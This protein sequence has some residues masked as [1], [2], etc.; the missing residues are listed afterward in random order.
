MYE[1]ERR[2]FEEKNEEM[3]WF[4]QD[5]FSAKTK[6][7]IATKLEYVRDF[8]A[9]L[10]WLL[11]SYFTSYSEITE[12]T[13]D[14]LNTLTFEHYQYF[15]NQLEQ[16]GNGEAAVNRKIGSL[17][18][19]TKYLNTIED[20]KG[21]PL[22]KRNFLAKLSRKKA[23]PSSRASTV[24]G[25]ILKNDAERKN[26]VNF[27]EYEYIP[28]NKRAELYYDNNK[29]RD[30]AIVSLILYSGIKL[31]E[32][33]VLVVSDI[34]FTN[35]KIKVNRKSAKGDYYLS[36][37]YFDGEALSYLESYINIR[38]SRYRVPSSEQ[39]L[40]LACRGYKSSCGQRINKSTIQVLINKYSSAYGRPEITP[41]RLRQT[42][43]TLK[44][45]EVDHGLLSE[46][47]G[48][49]INSADVYRLLSANLS[50]EGETD[51]AKTGEV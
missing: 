17:R 1:I 6:L 29:E 3:P 5:F 49:T 47:M 51:E 8:E 45:D 50:D 42:Y 39:A 16:N 40:F 33:V 14:D 26:F 38:T 21:Y 41:K 7:S 23:G 10:S 15:F 24:H 4:I 37:V 12:L 9:F 28:P 30:L 44:Y 43:G 35:R 31:N 11:E 27:I 13:M 46:L 36:Y 19:L 34:D 48:I 2:A 18:S 32:L 22:L 20:E 25:K